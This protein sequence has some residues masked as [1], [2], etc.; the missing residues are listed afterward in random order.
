VAQTREEAAAEL[1]TLP[2]ASAEWVERHI[3]ALPSA[4]K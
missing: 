1:S 4:K 2:G 3:A